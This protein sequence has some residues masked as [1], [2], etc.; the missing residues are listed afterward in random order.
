MGSMATRKDL[1]D[2]LNNP[3][4]AQNLNGLIEDLRRALMDYQVRIP[5]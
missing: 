4:N 3:K 1:V 5:K 2:F